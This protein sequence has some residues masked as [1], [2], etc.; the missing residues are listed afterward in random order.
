[1][2][3]TQI[4]QYISSLKGIFKGGS[5]N[6]A[7]LDIGLSAVKVCETSRSGSGEIKILKYASVPLPEGA[8]IE[9]EIH[10][11]SLSHRA[12]AVRNRSIK[13]L[14]FNNFRS[15]WLHDPS[16]PHTSVSMWRRGMPS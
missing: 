9:D 1:M 10:D 5:S 8:L 13:H 6:V 7:G 11:Q 15:L 2:A 16:L 3:G 12:R 14:V 4:N